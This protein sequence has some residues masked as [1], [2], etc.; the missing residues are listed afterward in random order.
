MPGPDAREALLTLKSKQ[1]KL[2]LPLNHRGHVLVAEVVLFGARRIGAR[3]ERE[4]VQEAAIAERFDPV[5]YAA[6]TH[7][8]PRS[9]RAVAA[10]GQYPTHTGMYTLRLEIGRDQPTFVG[11]TK[12]DPAVASPPD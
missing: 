5:F 11:Y 3:R 7:P 2:L 9:M 8:T 6:G 4:V 1:S 12:P 10:A